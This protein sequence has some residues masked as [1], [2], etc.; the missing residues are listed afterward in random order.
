MSLLPDVVFHC[1]HRLVNNG[2]GD[3]APSCPGDNRPGRW[4]TLHEAVM[5]MTTPE[6]YVCRGCG[7]TLGAVVSRGIFQAAE[8]TP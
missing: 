2:T 6:D 1:G 4:V 5:M 8:P 3:Y 7:Q